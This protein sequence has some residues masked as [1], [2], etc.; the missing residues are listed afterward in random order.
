MYDDRDLIDEEPEEDIPKNYS[1]GKQ[2]EN[3]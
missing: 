1:L 2:D 3:C